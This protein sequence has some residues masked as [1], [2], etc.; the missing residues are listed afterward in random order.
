MIKYSKNKKMSWQY[1]LANNF[2]MMK[3]VMIYF[4][5]TK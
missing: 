5:Q 2:F 1:A 4:H 3:R